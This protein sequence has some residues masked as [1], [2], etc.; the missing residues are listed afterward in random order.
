MSAAALTEVVVWGV[1][2]EGHAGGGCAKDCPPEQRDWYVAPP[3]HTL[4]AKPISVVA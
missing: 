2:G 1:P 4:L 3:L